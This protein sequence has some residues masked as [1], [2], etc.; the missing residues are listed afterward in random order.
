MISIVELK[1]E[2]EKINIERD[3]LKKRKAKDQYSP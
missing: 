2:L 1:N 3:G